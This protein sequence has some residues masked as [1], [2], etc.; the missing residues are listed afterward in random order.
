MASGPF[1]R[2][3]EAGE[4]VDGR[5]AGWS[6]SGDIA[7]DDSDGGPLQP[8][9]Y[10]LTESRHLVPGDGAYEHEFGGCLGVHDR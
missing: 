5:Q 7:D 6:E 1:R 2:E 8:Y 4:E 9:P 3:L 10:V